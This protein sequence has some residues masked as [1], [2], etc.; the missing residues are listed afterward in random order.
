MKS[1]LY[2][3]VEILPKNCYFSEEAKY[4]C[5]AIIAVQMSIQVKASIRIYRELNCLTLSVALSGLQSLGTEADGTQVI[6]ASGQM[7]LKTHWRECK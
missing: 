3:H 2:L 5:R 6:Q 4:I 7:I 1:V